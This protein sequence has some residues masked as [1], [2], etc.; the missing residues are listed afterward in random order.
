M[1]EFPVI[2]GILGWSA[3]LL[4]LC[5]ILH[6]IIGYMFKELW[7]LIKMLFGKRPG[8]IDDVELIGMNHFPFTGYK[9]L[10]WCGKM[11]YRNDALERRRKEWDT[12]GYR[13]S[14]NHET[15][16]LMQARMC[17]SWIKYY[18]R[19]F[20]DWV[21]GGIIMAPVSSAYYTTKYESEAYANEEDFEYCN[22]Y[23][24][25]NLSKYIFKNRK[26]L[27]KQIGGTSKDWKKY[28]KS[29]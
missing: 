1:I 25:S 26:K 8:E 19:Y 24:G 10:M 28:V 23:D 22:N 9:Y 29:L 14:K 17:G 21:K 3:I 13:V 11:I 16:H 6:L 7:Q 4:I 12:Y 15:I 27:Y 2:V 20:C 5:L 18:W